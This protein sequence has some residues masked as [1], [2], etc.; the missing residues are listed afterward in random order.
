MPFCTS[1]RPAG[2][3]SSAFSQVETLTARGLDRAGCSETS[4]P[5]IPRDLETICLKCLEK[6]P[7]K[8]YVSALALAEDLRRFAQDLAD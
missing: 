6:E 4:R 3:H 2:R 7:H 1:R 5:D 8:R